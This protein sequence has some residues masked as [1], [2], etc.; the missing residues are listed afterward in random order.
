MEIYTRK[1]SLKE[2]KNK[3]KGMRGVKE[4]RKLV[5]GKMKRHE[6]P[7]YNEGEKMMG[8]KNDTENRS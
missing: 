7:D 1:F 6:Y 2:D 5:A 4:K 3:A 8:D